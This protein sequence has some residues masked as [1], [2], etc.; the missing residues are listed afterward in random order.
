MIAAVSLIVLTVGVVGLFTGFG[1]EGDKC[2]FVG[3]I[4]TILGWWIPSP[5]FSKKEESEDE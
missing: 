4:G 2:T 3:F 1:D 5:L